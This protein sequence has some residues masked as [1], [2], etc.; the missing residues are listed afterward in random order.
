M[1]FSRVLS[2]RLSADLVSPVT[3]SID[4]ITVPDHTALL[5]SLKMMSPI[6]CYLV[7][8]THCTA[9]DG[10]SSRLVSVSPDSRS[11]V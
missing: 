7:L 8:G 11:S 2:L 4:Y 3:H 10:Q 1:V 9:R 5:T 6:H